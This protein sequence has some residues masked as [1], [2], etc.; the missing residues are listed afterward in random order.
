MVGNKRNKDENAE[1][2]T[3]AKETQRTLYGFRG[4]YVFAQTE[5]APLPSIGEVTGDASVYL[6]RLRQFVLA[7][8]VTVE[9]TNDI[10]P[11][12]GTAFGN[13]IRLLPGQTEAEELATLVHEYAHLG[14]GHSERRTTT[15]KTVRETEAEAV[16]FV[17][18]KAIGLNPNSSASYI[19][20]YHGNAE[21]LMESLEVVQQTSAV[22]LAAIEMEEPV[23]PET[24]EPQSAPEATAETQET[25]YLPAPA[26][27]AEAAQP[28][29]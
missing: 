25:G 4:V 21:L 1:Q 5:G 7:Q 17:V 19:Q 11:A 12:L 2:N 15:T 23:P 6:D 26:D 29:A 28:A 13:T 3:D 10:A 18:S 16:A 9:L 22:I 20:L 27:I 14:L 8:G 24:Q